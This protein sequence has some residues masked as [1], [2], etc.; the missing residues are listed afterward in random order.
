MT[1]KFYAD[2]SGKTNCIVC[3]R[4]VLD[5]NWFSRFPFGDGLIVTCRPSC[6]E[7][8][9]DNRGVYAAKLGMNWMGENAVA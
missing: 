8:F 3:E 6:M 1:K 2:N 5:G 9:L 4:E 7:K